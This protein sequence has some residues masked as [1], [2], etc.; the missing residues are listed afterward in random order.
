MRNSISRVKADKIPFSD[1]GSPDASPDVSEFWK[2]GE[3]WYISTG[4]V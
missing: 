4:R 1:E 3:G 2:Q